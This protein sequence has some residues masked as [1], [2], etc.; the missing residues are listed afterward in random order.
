MALTINQNVPIGDEHVRDLKWAM[1]G[2][3]ASQWG[4]TMSGKDAVDAVEADR[5]LV[6]AHTEI[7]RMGLDAG[8]G[9]MPS[10]S[11]GRAI[12]GSAVT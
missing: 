5:R 11:Y 10:R 12:R 6:A 9:R 1:A 2:E 4:K 3:L 8:L 7:P